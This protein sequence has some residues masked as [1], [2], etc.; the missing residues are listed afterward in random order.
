MKARA[1]GRSWRSSLGQDSD[2]I[3]AARVWTVFRPCLSECLRY[4]PLVLGPALDRGYGGEDEGEEREERDEGEKH[5]RQC[6]RPMCENIRQ[7]RA[8]HRRPGAGHVN[9]G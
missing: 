5:D 2:S 3:I 1:R 8:E 4:E 9:R 7:A 6:V